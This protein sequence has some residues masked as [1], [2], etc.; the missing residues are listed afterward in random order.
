MRRL[1]TVTLALLLGTTS[2]HAQHIRPAAAV[3]RPSSATRIFALRVGSRVPEARSRLHDALKGGLLGAVAGATV[4]AA[5]A[6][7]QGW[8]GSTCANT[9]STAGCGAR[10]VTGRDIAIGAAVGGL[11]GILSGATSER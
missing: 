11:L 7:Y 4:G 10:N 2:L 9:A 3:L 1:F 8:Q 6:V 5:A